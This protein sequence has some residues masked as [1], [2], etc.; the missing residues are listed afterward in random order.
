MLASLV[1]IAVGVTVAFSRPSNAA[2]T[3]AAAAPCLTSDCVRTAAEV[4]Y[5]GAHVVDD[6]TDKIHISCCRY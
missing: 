2:E 3:G 4:R 1:F 6:G 5:S